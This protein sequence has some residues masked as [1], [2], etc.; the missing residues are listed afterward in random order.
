MPIR[1]VLFDMDDVL[2]DYRV[3]GRIAALAR[4]SGRA[5]GAIRTA[6]WDSD[7]FDQSDTGRWTAEQALAEFGRRIGYPLSREEW[8]EARRIA[9]VPFPDMLALVERLKRV[10]KVAVLTNND[11]LVAETLPEL[12]PGLP[13]LFDGNI[14]VSSQFGRAK[15]EPEVFRACCRLMQFAPEEAFFTDDKEENVA[16]A[17]LAGLTAHVFH[18]EP[19]LRAALHEAGLK[20]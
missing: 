2:C 16:G 6:I 8:I 5:T 9:M 10:V 13:A 17:R 11:P 18:G 3:E 20:V 12:F 4:M 15:P 19:G 7:Y 1:L 14:F